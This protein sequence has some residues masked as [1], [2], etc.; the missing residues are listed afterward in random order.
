MTN[1][2][3]VGV[4][5]IGIDF[6][7]LNIELDDP[8]D[9]GKAHAHLAEPQ[10]QAGV[11]ARPFSEDQK[12]QRAPP[13]VCGPGSG[14]KDNGDLFAALD[15]AVQETEET[16]WEEQVEAGNMSKHPRSSRPRRCCAL[17]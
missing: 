10:Q 11:F 1:G 16:Q 4:D 2:S 8:E 9:G 14:Q 3:A 13:D 15:E 6:D 17:Q 12:H 5:A 7:D